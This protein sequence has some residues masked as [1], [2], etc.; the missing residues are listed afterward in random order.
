ME[1][2]DALDRNIHT[3]H[4]STGWLAPA[5]LGLLMNGVS[6]MAQAPTEAKPAATE[7]ES[8]ETL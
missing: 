6:A 7:S 3:R 1:S 2:F 8:A 4:I 5:F